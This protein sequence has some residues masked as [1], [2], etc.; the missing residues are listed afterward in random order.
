MKCEVCKKELEK[1]KNSVVCS[2]H[3]K[4]EC[5]KRNCDLINGIFI[6]EKNE[7][8]YCKKHKRAYFPKNLPY[9]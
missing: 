9:N 3:S 8:W 6:G 4:E 1:E 2:E 7:S 5:D